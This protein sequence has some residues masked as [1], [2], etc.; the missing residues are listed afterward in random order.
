[1]KTDTTLSSRR[2]NEAHLGHARDLAFAISILHFALPCALP[3]AATVQNGT[4]RDWD[5]HS[6]PDF[7]N[8]LPNCFGTSPV[9]TAHPG[10]RGFAV[11][12]KCGQNTDKN[13]NLV[14]LL[15]QLQPLATLT[16]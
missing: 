3:L 8:K 13:A 14:F 10:W 11:G 16:L 12:S 6:Q 1:M 5:W 15:P 7:P 9:L 2:G 4:F